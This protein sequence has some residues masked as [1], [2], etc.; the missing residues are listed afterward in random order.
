MV[1]AEVVEPYLVPD[2]EDSEAE[3]EE[4]EVGGTGV[5]LAERLPRVGRE[6]GSDASTAI[7]VLHI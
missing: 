5:D 4:E 7:L 6:P 1:A 2:V 3:A